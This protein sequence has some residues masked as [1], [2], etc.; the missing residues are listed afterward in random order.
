MT[1]LALE[2]IYS[3]KVRDLYAIDEKRMLMV[4]TDRLSAFDVILPEPITGKGEI[5]TQI[6][7]FWFKKLQH[8]MPNHFTG[9]TVYDVLPRQ[10]ADKIAKRAVVV[11]KLS[12]LKIEAIVRGY[13]SGSGWRDY[14]Q[15][16][17]VCGIKLPA[18]LREAEQLPEVIFT[19]SSKAAV[20][21]HDENISLSQCASLLG[22]ELTEQVSAKAIKL[23]SEAA[24]YAR[25]KGIIIADTKF[26]FG[27]DENGV[28]T[29]MDEVLTPDSSRFWSVDSYQVGSNPPSF[30]KQ[31]IRDW[32]VESG[33]NKQPPAPHI[34]ADIIA[35]T[36]AKYEEALHL[37]AGA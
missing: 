29:L 19:P 18:G 28:L 9:E 26:E 3:G 12:P 8:I 35:K 27:L 14:Q 10:Q 25:S 23:Y 22:E 5:L 7:N 32:L 15:T 33:W 1:E 34:P 2:K 21:D 17:A 30:D 11:K 13:L 16:G 24:D 6:S 4:A 36:L 37:I 20:G 31:F